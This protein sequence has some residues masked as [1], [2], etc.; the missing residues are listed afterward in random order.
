MDRRRVARGASF[1]LRVIPSVGLLAVSLAG[2]GGSPVPRIP[3]TTGPTG[4]LRLG[5]RVIQTG[6][7]YIEGYVQ[8]VSVRRAHDGLLV[9]RGADGDKPISAHLRLPTGSYV[10]YSWTRVCDA[11]CGNL[12]PPSDGCRGAL[13]VRSGRSVTL[14]VRNGPGIRC[15]V[16]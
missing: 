1:A 10:V 5:E 9:Y 12:D 8:Y 7:M 3:T 15:R 6:A 11:N 13:R 16:T 4:Y 14:I 2:C